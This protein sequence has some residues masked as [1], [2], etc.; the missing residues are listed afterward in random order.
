MKSSLPAF[1]SGAVFAASTAGM[2]WLSIQLGR[3][4]LWAQISGG[5][6]TCHLLGQIPFGPPYWLLRIHLHRVSRAMDRDEEP[7]P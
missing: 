4:M 6:R 2:Y 3:F 5:C 7:V 1:L